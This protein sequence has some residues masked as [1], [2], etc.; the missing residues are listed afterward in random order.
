MPRWPGGWLPGSSQ[1]SLPGWP[2]SVDFSDH[3]APWSVLSKIPGAST[4]T[5]TFPFL[6]ASVET[7]DTLRPLSGS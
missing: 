6:T 7:F 2:A 3:V 1:P 4:P 5:S